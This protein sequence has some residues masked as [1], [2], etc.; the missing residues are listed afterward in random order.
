MILKGTPPYKSVRGTNDPENDS[1]FKILT[2]G[3]TL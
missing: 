1:D 2:P 3:F